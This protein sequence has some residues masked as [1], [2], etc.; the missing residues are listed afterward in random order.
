MAR[1]DGRRGRVRAWLA[2]AGPL[3]LA[4]AAGL[5]GC[6]APWA[7]RTAIE[8]VVSNAAGGAPEAGVWVIAE[9][10]SLPTPFRKIVATDDEGR[11]LVPDL[12]KGDYHLWV[13]GYG[14]KDSAAVDAKPGAEVKLSVA[15][16]ADARAPDSRKC[17]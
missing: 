2:G 15:S 3:A 9:T 8:G 6:K 5:A 14:L 13:R 16:A 1:W 10:A 17:T 11:F 12:P 7:D 4:L